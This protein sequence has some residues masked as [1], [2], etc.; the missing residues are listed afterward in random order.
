MRP[1]F[2]LHDDEQLRP[3]DTERPP[4]DEPEIERKEEHVVH[5]ANVALGDLLPGHRG[6]GQEDAQPRVTSA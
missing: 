4:D 5:T 3:D 1:D 6:G 2:G